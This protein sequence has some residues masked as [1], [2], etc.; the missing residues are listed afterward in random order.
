ME[1]VFAVVVP[2]HA[3]GNCTK[4][5]SGRLA[6]DV[7]TGGP[8]NALLGIAP[9]WLSLIDL[10]YL[11]SAM[12]TSTYVASTMSPVASGSPFETNFFASVP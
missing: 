5:W 2:P 7:S 8:W 10:R 1:P 3:F 11:S 6:D 9:M 12:C 4:L